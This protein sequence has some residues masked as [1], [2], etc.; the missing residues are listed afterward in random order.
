[1]RIHR[2]LLFSGFLLSLSGTVFAQT[3][4]TQVPGF[5][6]N[7]QLGETE[8]LQSV[9]TVHRTE[10][11][12]W[13]EGKTP[14]APEGFKVTKFAGNLRNPR[15]LYVLPN[16]DVLVAEADTDKEKS[17][18]RITILRDKNNDGFAETRGL[19]LQEL[20][21]PF[22]MLVMGDSFYV[23]NTDGVWRYPYHRGQWRITGKGK[24]IIS[25]PAGGYNNHWTR[26]IIASSDHAKILVSVGS[27][28]NVAEH[29]MRNE[30]RRANILAFNP[31]GNNESIYASGLRNPV[32]MGI[33]PVDGSVW[34]VV[35][36]RDQLGN[37]LVPDYLTH[38]ERDGFDGWPY[39]YFGQHE[40]PRRA[41][42][43][44]D[45]V[46][47]ALVPDYG[48][49]SH[50]ASLGMTF[51]TQN[52]FPAAYHNGVFI[53]QHGSWNRSDFSGYRVIFIPFKN[54]KPDGMP[55][56]FLNGFLV[57]DKSDDA[58]GRPAGV[59][60]Q[61]NGAL[62]IADDVGNSVWQVRYVGKR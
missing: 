10:N 13:P 52:A 33:Y 6:P 19:F 44:A 43:R 2:V 14:T 1:M 20:N 51:Y 59:T 54:G 16:N 48:L 60:V 62:L 49:G 21:Q 56:D 39:S 25:L 58:Y 31:D 7:P 32:G 46:A 9:L 55:Q 30:A 50:T 40:D 12:G 22:G 42:E 45:L 41:G 15:W 17:A 53:G 23:A 29:G 38:V 27:S 37:D 34:T 47:K 36:E 28:S 8:R 11:I 61:P 5:G 26:N 4:S 18:N 35:N 24:Q 57:G 3:S